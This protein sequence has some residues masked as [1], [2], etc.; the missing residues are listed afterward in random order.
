[1]AVLHDDTPLNLPRS[2]KARA[3]LAYLVATGH[4]YG[5]DQLCDLL[6]EG[7]A[8]PRAELRW[9]LS[10]IR[11]LLD[12]AG[13]KRLVADQRCVGFE[14]GNSAI[15][16]LQLRNLW[17]D[18]PTDTDTA[19]L[20]QAA[21]L[22]RGPF[23]Q[24][25]NLPECYRFDAW[26]VAERETLHQLHE[27]VLSTL[28]TRLGDNPDAALRCAR[29]RILLDPLS[30]D[31]HAGLIKLL[32]DLGRIDEARQRFERCQRMLAQ[33][34]G[35]RPSPALEGI[36]R[37][38]KKRPSAP[39]SPRH[40]QDTQVSTAE[41][42]AGREPECRQLDRFVAEGLAGESLGAL[43]ITGE[44]GIGKTR[45]LA[46]LEERV[47]AAGGVCVRG[48]AYEVEQVRP[49]AVWI[50]ALRSLGTTAIPEP[51]RRDL[52]PLLPELGNFDDTATRRSRMFDAVAGLLCDHA[53]RHGLVVMMADDLQW[54]DE[55]SVALT[56]H[57]IRSTPGRRV[58]FVAA[59]RS[60]ELVAN[61][62]LA[63]LTRMLQGDERI[64]TLALT[65]LNAEATAE[66]VGH[67]APRLD[68]QRVF[69]E[70]D[71]N[72]L[73]TK[74]VARAMSRHGEVVD[75][76]M[77]DLI[78]ARLSG[79]ERA[80][81]E[82]VP[83]LAVLGRR[84]NLDVLAAVT[85]FPA[86]ALLS[87][88]TELEQQAIIQV[89]AEGGY[90]FVHNV[91]R[92]VAYQRMSAP[93][94]RMIHLRIARVLRRVMQREPVRASEVATH[95][96][97]GG[98]HELAASACV[99]AGRHGLRI[100]AYEEVVASIERGLRQLDHIPAHKRIA[101][102][103]QLFELY[104]HS[105]MMSYWPDD[106]E[107]RLWALHDQARARKLRLQSGQHCVRCQHDKRT[108]TTAWTGSEPITGRSA[109]QTH[110]AGRRRLRRSQTHLQRHDRPLSGADRPL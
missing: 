58:L 18:A 50:D 81:G 104:G 79:L 22:L 82:L 11:P 42:L 91:I 40:R 108:D 70:S 52:V 88:L 69:A 94:R 4:T 44:P 56:H 30:E 100:F 29:D 110:S 53:D 57:V 54:L 7:P 105:G 77:A 89:D 21:G 73:F 92:K 109:R 23:L 3:L 36:R 93:A 90:E 84:F 35:R 10:K 5:R 51:Y 55:A 65:P 63:N 12:D 14:A 86:T 6:W 41:P 47:V 60:G 20:Q 27:A 78:E 66:L 28:M 76:T 80:T 8:D 75:D 48:R 49:Y 43:L 2:K 45:L 98:D 39:Q 31:A 102:H 83:W 25:L 95:A 13:E 106:L 19:T 107:Q 67:V 99:Q 37:S 72:P 85:K 59:G 74:E 33:E 71:G 38:I 97:Q 17:V 101:M 16:L 32:A 26:C 46:A 61:A 15:D 62:A 96:E 103:L 64:T 24:G 1:M 34:F 87:A 9:T 68:S